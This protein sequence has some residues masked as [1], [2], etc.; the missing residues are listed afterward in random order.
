MSKAMSEGLR[1]AWAD[2]KKRKR[3]IRGLRRVNTSLRQSIRDSWTTERRKR[4]A[5]ITKESWANPTSRAKRLRAL[6]QSWL[7]PTVRR[8]R[9]TGLKRIWKAKPALREQQSKRFR[10]LWADPTKLAQMRTRQAEIA[11]TPEGRHRRSQASLRMWKNPKV[12]RR[13][14]KAIRRATREPEE[15]RKRSVRSKRMWANIK[16]AGACT[17]ASS[18][19]P[20]NIGRPPGC[21]PDTTKRVR[22]AAA[23]SILQRLDPIHWTKRKQAPLLFPETLATAYRNTKTFYTRNRSSIQALSSTMDTSLAQRIV[24]GYKNSGVIL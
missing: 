18:S 10:A 14:E 16:T 22:L 8:K 6:E 13:L 15:R 20:K 5:E 2:P 3:W 17:V 24:E 11:R 12:R 19:K 7:D 4:A 9:V 1:R 21:A 23:L